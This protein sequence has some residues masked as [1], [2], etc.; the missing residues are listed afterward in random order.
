MRLL[1]RKVSQRYISCWKSLFFNFKKTGGRNERVVSDFNG[2]C[3]KEDG[4]L[5]TW[6]H[7]GG[8]GKTA[9][10][11]RGECAGGGKEKECFC[12]FFRTVCGSSR[13]NSDCGSRDFRLF[14][15][16]GEHLCH[17]GCDR[18][19]CAARNGPVCKGG[20]VAGESEGSDVAERESAALRREGGDSGEGSRAGRP[21]AAGGGR[22]GGGGRQNPAQLFTAGE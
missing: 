17:S 12:G 15:E 14:G 6:T 20:E 9:G 21:S 18:A 19:Q 22:H 13:G 11:I 8:G 4:D 16:S 10:A 5:R 3:E 1:A 2:R 7:N